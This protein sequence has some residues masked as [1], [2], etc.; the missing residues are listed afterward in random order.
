M[1]SVG[2]RIEIDKTL[3][4][5]VEKA[6]GVIVDKIELLGEELELLRKQFWAAF[7]IDHPELVQYRCE[8]AGGCVVVNKITEEELCED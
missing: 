5:K 7:F 6:E 3:L 1:V 4:A 8:V 2:R